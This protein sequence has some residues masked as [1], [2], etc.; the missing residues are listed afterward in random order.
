M[1]KNGLS[2]DYYSKEEQ[3]LWEQAYSNTKRVPE[4]SQVP[5]RMPLKSIRGEVTSKLKEEKCKHKW[6]KLTLFTSVTTVC[7]HCD[8]EKKQK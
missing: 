8:I 5:Y 2:G 4:Y 6:I 7:K 3:D 1:Y